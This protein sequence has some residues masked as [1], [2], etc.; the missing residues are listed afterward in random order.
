M[1]NP[2]IHKELAAGRWQQMPFVEQ[3]ANIGSEVGRAFNWRNKGNEA[4]AQNAF[5]RALELIDLTLASTRNFPKLKEVARTREA[6]VDYFCFSN[7]YASTETAFVNYFLAFN[8]AARRN[9]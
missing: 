1:S 7:E 3:M 6:L 2:P 5:E 4:Y 9:S 8:Y